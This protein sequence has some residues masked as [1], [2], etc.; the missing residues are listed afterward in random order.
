[1]TARYFLHSPQTISSIFESSP[2]TSDD[3]NI[4][5]I[6]ET[7]DDAQLKS[8]RSVSNLM[9]IV[10]SYL[11]YLGH[12]STCLPPMTPG[13]DSAAPYTK[14]LIRKLVDR[15]RKDENE[16]VFQEH[17]LSSNYVRAR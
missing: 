13:L 6:L 1:M 14:A 11:N 17:W 16:L 7:C 9:E 12:I 3:G 5:R 15:V 4:F 10:S 8:H 2:A